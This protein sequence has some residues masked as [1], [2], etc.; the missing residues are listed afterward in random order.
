MRKK[1]ARLGGYSTHGDA[2]DMPDLC[3][4]DQGG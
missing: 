3:L 2:A 1:L 4:H